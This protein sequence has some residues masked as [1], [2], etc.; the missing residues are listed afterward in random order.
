V[1][2]DAV[3]KPPERYLGSQEGNA[4]IGVLYIWDIEKQLEYSGCDLQEEDYKQST[5]ESIGKAAPPGNLFIER[6]MNEIG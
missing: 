4:V 1:S 3:Y 6:Q 5:P 2:V